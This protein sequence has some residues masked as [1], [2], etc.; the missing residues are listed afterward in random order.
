MKYSIT[1]IVQREVQW[2]GDWAG[3]LTVALQLRCETYYKSK[4]NV[5]QGA[6]DPKLIWKDVINTLKK[7]KVLHWSFYSYFFY[8]SFNAVFALK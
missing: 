7:E 3:S 2:G 4:N 1:Y 5:S 6:R 8:F